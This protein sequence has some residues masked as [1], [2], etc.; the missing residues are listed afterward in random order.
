MTSTMNGKKLMLKTLAKSYTKTKVTEG[1]L[2]TLAFFNLY[3]LPITSKR[4]WELLYKAEATLPEVESELNRLV[5]LDLVINKN[6]L[7]ALEDWDEKI[8]SRNQAEINKRWVRIKKYFW[9]ISSIPFVEHVAVINSV[10]MGNADSESDIDFFVITKPN[11]LYFVRTWIILLFKVLGVYKNRKVTNE[12]FCFGFYMTSDALSIKNLLLPQ[13]DPYLT[14]WLGTIIPISGVHV[15]EKFVKENRWVYSWLPNFKTTQRLDSIKDLKP[16]L[17]L[18]K[19]WQ[20]V[21]TVPALILEP[22]L[23]WIHIRHTFKLPE[24]H[25]KT[26]STIAD[27]R[28]LKLHAL[29]PRKNLRNRFNEIL[30][31]YR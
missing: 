5:R 23:R 26:S 27:K 31:K 22:I 21:F 18:K 19:F 29:D 12:R 30:G 13:E 24:N 16:F 20:I 1:I 9:L 10:A 7:Y 14:F 11:K 17:K 28:M 4:L 2:A 8:Y 25:W 6:G 15:Y 3:K